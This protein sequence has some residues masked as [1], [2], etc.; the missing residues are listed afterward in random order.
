MN[1]GRLSSKHVLHQYK[2]QI[3]S[4]VSASSDYFERAYLLKERIVGKRIHTHVLFVYK[5]KVKT[6]KFMDEVCFSIYSWAEERKEDWLVS[7]YKKGY[8]FTITL[9]PHF[10]SLREFNELPPETKSTLEK[11]KLS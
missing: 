5:R 11:N 9:Y 4:E 7:L 2:T 10:M 3:L 6:L 8:D 1:K